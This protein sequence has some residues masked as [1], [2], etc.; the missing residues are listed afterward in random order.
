[1]IVSSLHIF[2]TKM[3]FLKNSRSLRKLDI[4]SATFTGTEERIGI[5]RNAVSATERM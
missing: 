3:Y 5:V 2:Q 4:L 1:M